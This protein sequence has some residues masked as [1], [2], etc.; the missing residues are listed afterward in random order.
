MAP[1]TKPAAA[2]TAP[3]VVNPLDPYAALT[4]ALDN[5]DRDAELDP[6]IEAFR[7]I[8]GR[9]EL[10]AE[11]AGGTYRFV[12]RFDGDPK[13]GRV[14]MMKADHPG[15]FQVLLFC[16]EDGHYFKVGKKLG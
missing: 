9:A 7:A 14:A 13:A 15:A 4:A 2:P 1:K 11:P 12:S 16:R 3:A 10:D 6:S 5:G 8:G